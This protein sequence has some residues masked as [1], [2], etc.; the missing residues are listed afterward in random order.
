MSDDSRIRVLLADPDPRVRAEMRTILER[1]GNLKLVGEAGVGDDLVA[2][3][4]EAAPDIVMSALSFNGRSSLAALRA[5]ARWAPS[6]KVL[7]V[8]L[9]HDSRYVVSALHA[10]ASGFLLKEHASEELADA[11]DALASGRV[12]ISPGIAGIAETGIDR[13]SP[14]ET[15]TY[16]GAAEWLRVQEGVQK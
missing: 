11:V 6:V 10:G 8:S 14:Q 4:T 13:T 15:D 5:L 1:E 9:H 3:V 2:L 12:Y 16:R 7:V